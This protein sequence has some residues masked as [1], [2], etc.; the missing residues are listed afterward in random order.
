MK[1]SNPNVTLSGHNPQSNATRSKYG[2]KAKEV[3]LDS[4]NYGPSQLPSM[5]HTH[6]KPAKV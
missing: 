3:Q 2:M 6:N 1:L 4:G 5:T